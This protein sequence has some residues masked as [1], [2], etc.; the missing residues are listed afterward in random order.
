[1]LDR[2]GPTRRQTSFSRSNVFGGNG[3]VR[4]VAT[5]FERPLRVANRGRQC[6]DHIPLPLYRSRL[7]HCSVRRQRVVFCHLRASVMR[8]HPA[9]S[10]LSSDAKCCRKQTLALDTPGAIGRVIRSVRHAAPSRRL[11]G[12][13]ASR[14]NVD[15]ARSGRTNLHQRH[16]RPLVR[17]RP[18]SAPRYSSRCPT[19]Q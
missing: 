7:R 13:R 17:V 1:M 14:R 4:F 5:G 6:P 15:Y 16:G 2:D 9:S 12:R 19:D 10:G 8:Q 18:R 11:A 3:S